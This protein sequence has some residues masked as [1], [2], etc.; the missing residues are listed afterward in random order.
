M[1]HG[2]YYVVL[3]SSLSIAFINVSCS[4]WLELGPWYRVWVG[5]AVATVPVVVLLEC[6]WLL[7]AA[8]IYVT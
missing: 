8:N 3:N 5:Q 4:G 2:V 6:M 1:A 7:P